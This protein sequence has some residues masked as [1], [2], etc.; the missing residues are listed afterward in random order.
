MAESFA[1]PFDINATP[2]WLSTL[3]PGCAPA[4]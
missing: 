2:W 1:N 4:E 3:L